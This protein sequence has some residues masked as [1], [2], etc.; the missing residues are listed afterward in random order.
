MSPRYEDGEIA[1]IDPW[2]RPR[3]GDYVVAQI[4]TNDLDPPLAFIKKLVR[5]NSK[6][7][8]LVQ[9]NPAKELKFPGN[10]VDT[11]HYI[12]LAGECP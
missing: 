5:H 7:L 8:V 3:P 2:Q 9:F 1:F 10:Q 4:K 12:R 6:E 11:V